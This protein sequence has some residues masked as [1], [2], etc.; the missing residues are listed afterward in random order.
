MTKLQNGERIARKA[1]SGRFPHLTHV[2]KNLIKTFIAQNKYSSSD[3]IAADLAT[4]QPDGEVIAARTV[5]HYLSKELDYRYSR[6]QRKLLLNDANK[7]ARLTWAVLHQGDNFNTTVFCD[8][9]CFALGPDGRLL[10][11]HPRHKPI[12]EVS[13]Y[14][15]KLHMLGAVS[16]FATVGF[17][18]FAPTWNART[19]STQFVADI[20]PS[21]SEEIGVSSW[22]TPQH[23]G[24]KQLSMPFCRMAAL[25]SSSSLRAR[26]T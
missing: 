18:A 8:E 17:L 16:I 20:V 12:V 22:I 14:P 9:A 11:W 3:R 10:T 15:A 24:A 21:A 2:G 19:F 5:R 7:N 6:P 25:K 26:L 4:Q 13:Q 1:R 23:T